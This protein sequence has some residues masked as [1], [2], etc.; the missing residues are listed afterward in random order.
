MAKP[1]E[2]RGYSKWQMSELCDTA[3]LARYEAK[4]HPDKPF[5]QQNN[6]VKRCNHKR[7]TTETKLQVSRLSLDTVAFKYQH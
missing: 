3:A 2:W 4:S 7:V 6:D 1:S 5:K